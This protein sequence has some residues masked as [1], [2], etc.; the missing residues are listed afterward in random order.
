MLAWSF[1]GGRLESL[2]AGFS[3]AG[4]DIQLPMMIRDDLQRVKR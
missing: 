1:T 2:A 3:E 4:I